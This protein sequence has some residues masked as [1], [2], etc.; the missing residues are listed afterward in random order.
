MQINDLRYLTPQI[1]CLWVD[2]FS[3]FGMGSVYFSLLSKVNDLRLSVLLFDSFYFDLIV[4]RV[5]S[6]CYHETIGLARPTPDHNPRAI[7]GDI[8]PL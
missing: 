7:R 4:A 5:L 8:C 2:S 1:L 3:L 6:N